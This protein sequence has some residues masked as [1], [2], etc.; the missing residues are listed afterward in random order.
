MQ[1]DEPSL[2]AV[3]GGTVPTASGLARHRSIDIPEASSSLSAIAERLKTSDVETWVHCCAA[4]APIDLVRGAGVAAVL[5]DLDQLVVADWDAMGSALEAGLV[6]GLGAV[7]TG[8][9]P[10]ADQVADRVLRS[11]RALDL[12][13]DITTRTV[14][15]PACGLVGVQVDRAVQ[16][17]R[18]LRTAAEIVTDQLV[19]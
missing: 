10:T 3:L 18:T 4:G 6:L 12:A 9:A 19:E 15:T 5:V 17:L 16:T 7:P 1:L 8:G 14:I 11:L 13:P 2:P